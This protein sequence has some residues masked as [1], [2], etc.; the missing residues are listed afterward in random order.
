MLVYGL[1][2]VAATWGECRLERNDDEAQVMMRRLVGSCTADERLTLA[3]NGEDVIQALQD[4]RGVELE[5]VVLTGDVMLDRLSVEAVTPK[6]LATPLVGE[7]LFSGHI[8]EVRRLRGPLILRHVQVQGVIATNFV[9]QGYLLAEGP[10]RIQDTMIQRSIDFSRTAFLEDVEF[11][12][13]NILFEGF[14]IQSVFSKGANFET[15]NFGTHSRFHKSAFGGKAVFTGSTF[16]G[17]AEFLEVMFQQEAGFANVHFAMGTGFSGSRFQQQATFTQAV[18]DR[19]AYFRFAEFDGDARFQGASF[20]A[21]TDFTEAKFRADWNFAQAKFAVVP[22]FPKA[23]AEV[24]AGPGNRWKDARVQSGL[25]AFLFIV[26]MV[27]IFR[28]RRAQREKSTK[29]S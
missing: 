28:S 26:L 12:G 9:M 19:E 21:A 4:G 20:G 29:S 13:S 10:V 14:F 27:F 11:S 24:L 2:L 16:Q 25:F 6:D 22:Q 18:F 5:G 23:Q 8:E 7:R 3:I 1:C 15:V 17:L